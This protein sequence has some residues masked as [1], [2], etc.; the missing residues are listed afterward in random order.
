MSR[1]GCAQRRGSAETVVPVPRAREALQIV[2][3]LARG[4]RVTALERAALRVVAAELTEQ[5][6]VPGLRPDQPIRSA[7]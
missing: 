6:V 4:V 7:T 1:Q 3:Q 5:L 2:F